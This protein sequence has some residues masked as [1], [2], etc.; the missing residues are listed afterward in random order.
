M[1]VCLFK[2]REANKSEERLK[3]ALQIGRT[4]VAV[5]PELQTEQNIFRDRVPRKQR[6]I[7]EYHTSIWTRPSSR[8]TA[9]EQLAQRRLFKPRDAAQ[10]RALAASAWTEQAYEAT[11]LDCH[12]QVV[13]HLKPVASNR[14]R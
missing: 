7:L 12:V 8:P 10:E 9:H 1:W 5:V 2:P 6:I 13:Q 3:L 4:L 11:G 14:K